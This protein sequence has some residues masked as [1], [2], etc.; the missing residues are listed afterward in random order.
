MSD[1]LSAELDHCRELAMPPGS[2]FEFTGRFLSASELQPLLALYA[3]RQAIV[4]IPYLSAD[5]SVKWA[6]LKW[7][8]DE[9]LAD[10]ASPS[11]H[12]ILRVLQASGAR[13]RLPDSM[14]QLL[15]RDTVTQ[16]DTAP[17]SDEKDLF[18]RDAALGCAEI[19]LELTLDDAGIDDR[20]K[21][22]LG[23]AMNSFRLVSGFAANNRSGVHHLPL[24]ILAKYNVGSAQLEQKLFPDEFSKIFM[25]LID[26]TLDWYSQGISGLSISSKEKNGKHLRLRW[27]MEKRRLAA[28]RKDLDGFL[29]SGQ[30]FGPADAWFAWRFLRNLK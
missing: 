9:I 10:P 5:D 27:A 7:W 16:I 4:T 12:P 30:Q 20:N 13:A 28:I 24:S 14:L 29:Q 25:Q 19:E 6:K 3:L 21:E 18:E 23:A 8:S 17:V 11:R 15:I 26:L 22:F 2:V 1:I